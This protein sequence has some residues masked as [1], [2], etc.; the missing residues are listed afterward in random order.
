MS[1][2][3]KYIERIYLYVI[4]TVSGIIARLTVTFCLTIRILLNNLVVFVG[5][6]FRFVFRLSS[7]VRK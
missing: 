7:F 6:L 4:F 3:D 5:F 1:R 2:T